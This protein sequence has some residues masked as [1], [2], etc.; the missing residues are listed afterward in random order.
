MW[1]DYNLPEIGPNESLV[2]ILI[3]SICNTDK[4]VLKGYRPDFKGVLGHR[5]LLGRLSSL[6]TKTLLASV[7]LEK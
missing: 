5:N 6:T 7:W 3:S 1:E 4:E 2:K